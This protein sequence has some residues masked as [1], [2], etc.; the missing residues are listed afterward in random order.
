MFKKKTMILALAAIGIMTFSSLMASSVK[1]SSIDDIEAT[2]RGYKIT[3]SDNS[4]ELVKIFNKKTSKKTK[5]NYYE[6]E[7]LVL[8]LQ[9][10]GKR[11]ALVDVS[12]GEVLDKVKLTDESYKLNSLNVKEIQ[13]KKCAVVTSRSKKRDES[14]I[15]LLRINLSNEEITKKDSLDFED[16]ELK[17]KQTEPK[18]KKI[19]LED[20]NGN[21]YEISVDDDLEMTLEE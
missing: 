21:D 3:Y 8:V 12:D 19:E 7:G 6:D 14:T 5:I 9:S 18:S 20:A 16:I 10:N 17:V 13:D 2:K 11:L 1:A 4:E 15:S